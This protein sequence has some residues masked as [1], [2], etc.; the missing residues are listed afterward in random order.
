MF[1]TNDNYNEDMSNHNDMPDFGG[2]ID[3]ENNAH[4]CLMILK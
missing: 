4:F 3:E 2:K 1:T